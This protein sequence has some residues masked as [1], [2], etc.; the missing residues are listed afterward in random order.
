MPIRAETRSRV[1]ALRLLYAWDLSG[2]P[3]PAPDAWARVVRLVGAAPAVEDR[4]LGL[5]ERAA[6]R[7][8]ELDALIAR[9]AERWRLERLGAVERN[10]LRLAALELLEDATP[11]RVVLDE[12]IRL[13][14]WFGGARAPAFVNGVLDRMARDL[15]RL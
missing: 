4:A 5:A 3:A 11:P 8:G 15:G 10:L 6:A 9:A 2:A 14:H 1:L 12:A 13:A 7:C